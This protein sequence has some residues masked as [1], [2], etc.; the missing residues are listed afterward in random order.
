MRPLGDAGAVLLEVVVALTILAVGGAAGV[1]M[2]AEAARAVG[3]ARA[4]DGELRAASHFMENVALW[5][6]A[7]LDRHLGARP[8]GAWTLSIDRPDPELYTAALADSSG[9]VLLRTSLFRADT[10]HAAP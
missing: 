9:R 2:A 8:Q 6:R 1:T 10:A 3:H 4:A 7:D 5:T